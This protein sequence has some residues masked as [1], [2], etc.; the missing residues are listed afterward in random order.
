MLISFKK[1]NLKNLLPLPM[2]YIFLMYV[3]FFSFDQYKEPRTLVL[4]G[5]NI[6]HNNSPAWKLTNWGRAGF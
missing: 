5:K 6:D 1:G 4:M 2:N 3:F